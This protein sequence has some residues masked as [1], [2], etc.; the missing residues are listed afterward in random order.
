[1]GSEPALEQ[2]PAAAAQHT[3]AGVSRIPM[4]VPTLEA[5]IV[6]LLPLVVHRWGRHRQHCR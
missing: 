4:L 6:A 1:M 5:G 2:F 3:F